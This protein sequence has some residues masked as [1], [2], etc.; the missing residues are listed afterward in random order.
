M[1]K[2]YY[3]ANLLILIAMTFASNYKLSILVEDS[4]IIQ[5]VG[6]SLTQEAL[7]ASTCDEF[8]AYG[9]VLLSGVE[10]ITNF[11]NANYL[12]SDQSRLFGIVS[13]KCIEESAIVQYLLQS[14]RNLNSTVPMLLLQDFTSHFVGPNVFYMSPALTQLFDAFFNLCKSLEWN[15]ISIIT[16]S[17]NKKA[18]ILSN[19]LQHA[20][21]K[22]NISTSLFMDLAKTSIHK[23]AQT[24]YTLN[25][26]KDS[27]IKIVLM[28]VLSSQVAHI[29]ADILCTAYQM[30][31][32][33]PQYAWVIY[34]DKLTDDIMRLS[35]AQEEFLEGTI[36]LTYDFNIP[37][38]RSTKNDV[39]LYSLQEKL[40]K[41]AVG[42]LKEA[43][44][45]SQDMLAVLK[46]I[47]Y[48]GITGNI[49]FDATNSVKRDSIFIQLR[50]TEFLIQTRIRYGKIQDNK[51]LLSQQ[52][53]PTSTLPFRVNTV[54]PLW[55][56]IVEVIVCAIAITA[57][58]V[59]FIY[60]RNE[61]EIKATSWLL[62]L[63]M[64][65][66]CYMLVANLL[67][68][69][70][71]TF[72]PPV[73]HFNT[74]SFSIWISVYGVP[75]TLISAVLLVKMLR[76]YH[77]FHKFHKLGKLSSNYAMVFY[78]FLIISP[79]IMVLVII[80]ALSSYRVSAI[81]TFH[82]YYVE[83]KYICMGNVTLYYQTVPVYQLLLTFCTAA[84]A[85]TTRKLRLKHFR[86]AKKV[87]GFFLTFLFTA[88][89][90]YILYGIFHS[91][92]QYLEGYII[93]HF[94]YN[95]LIF[96]CLGFLFVPKIYPVV[97][98]RYFK[99]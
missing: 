55:L 65:L 57:V 72:L 6:V 94:C 54:Y 98:K 28:T 8:T 49:M 7:N 15:R 91:N 71:R 82:T 25:E 75:L 35:C 14:K 93:I 31:M 77:I 56:I 33:W 69:A 50:N 70:I 16:N 26:I 19:Y 78:I 23:N 63:L 74:C 92:D 52:Q 44:N 58:L 61:P 39:N 86:D 88:V 47:H 5:D 30:N 68:H 84:V 41:D 64:I 67:A 17:Y 36:F 46:K 59:L 89:P 9:S 83:V 81:R 32:V 99:K 53:F 38:N 2:P 18:E 42:L 11:F 96:S 51:W 60:F 12:F 40:I 27:G 79:N 22:Q 76:V 45:K 4:V 20:S 48:E 37:L 97:Y 80:T 85:L 10:L 24:N 21:E 43:S 13:N 3:L 90:G 73:P 87:N 29:H 34:I 1:E 66:S 62:S 95:V